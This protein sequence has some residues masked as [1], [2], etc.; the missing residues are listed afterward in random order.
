[1]KL[2]IFVKKR[3]LVLT[4]CSANIFGQVIPLQK[5][6]FKRTLFVAM[7]FILQIYMCSCEIKY[8]RGIET[9]Q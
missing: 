4:P 8:I 1:M 6:F 2:I 5:I 3:N 7:T 9:L